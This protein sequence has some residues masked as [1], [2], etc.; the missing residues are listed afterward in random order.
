VFVFVSPT[1][2]D[3][4]R[5]EVTD[6]TPVNAMMLGIELLSLHCVTQH[7][8]MCMGEEVLSSGLKV[9]SAA[10]A[11]FTFHASYAFCLLILLLMYSKNVYSKSCMYFV[12]LK[13]K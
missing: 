8:R 4:S 9:T 13:I 12:F 3:K 5:E 1:F 6:V 7:F 11:N 2:D 10:S